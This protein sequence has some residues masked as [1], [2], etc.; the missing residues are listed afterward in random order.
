MF[1]T[2]QCT[3]TPAKA[4]IFIN[5][6]SIGY[7]TPYTIPKIL[8]GNYFIKYH[9]E[10]YRDDSSFVT[11]TSS[12]NFALYKYLID[13]TLWQDYTMANSGMFSQDLT[14]VTVNQYNVV[15]VGS[16][17]DRFFSFDGK[18]WGYYNNSFSYHI[19]CLATDK[20]NILLVGTPDY[21]VEYFGGA[22]FTI[23][24][25]KDKYSR[26]PNSKIQSITVD[27]FNDWYLGTQG[28]ITEVTA[29]GSWITFD[30]EVI[31]K[32]SVTCTT[33]D[34]DNN[35]WAGILNEGVVTKDSKGTWH[36]YTT[37]NSSLQSNNV[38]AIA[39]DM[40]GS[41]RVGYGTDNNFGHGL[42]EFADSTIHN[43]YI[44][45]SYT[46]TTSIFVDIDNKI[47]VGTNQ[48]IVMFTSPSSPVYFNY[49]NTGLN[50][51]GVT[52]FAED[53]FGSI[54]ISTSAGLYNYKNPH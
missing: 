28:G 3:S 18:N 2:L 54:W 14:C 48:G 11:I 33:V 23:F 1:G 20:N 17:F 13:T 19:N 25:S 37:S 8:P 12:K 47:W 26:L 22:S 34:K 40:Y 6:S 31:L 36:H 45:P 32:K 41:V 16:T 9:L 29:S 15:T 4:Q 27:K 38:T 24:D 5:D 21:L 43:Y 30:D 44:T 42:T 52:G 53:K 46:L 50:I 7:V 10:K 39:G 51:N 49:D 35:I